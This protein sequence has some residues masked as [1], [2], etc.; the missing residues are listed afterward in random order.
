MEA[1]GLFQVLSADKAN[2]WE[3]VVVASIWWEVCLLSSLNDPGG[4]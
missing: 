2:C 4:I 3:K 1:D